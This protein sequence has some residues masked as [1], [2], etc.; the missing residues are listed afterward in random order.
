MTVEITGRRIEPPEVSDDGS[1][2]GGPGVQKKFIIS[3]LLLIVASVL[4]LGADVDPNEE[5]RLMLAWHKPAVHPLPLLKGMDVKTLSL[6]LDAGN[7]MWYEPRPEPDRW[8]AVVGVKI[9]ASPEVVW[10]VVTDY[11]LQCKIMPESF[12]ECKTRYRRGAEVKNDYKM[13]TSVFMYSFSL[14]VVDLVIEEPP[15]RLRIKTVDGDV[16]G[17]E[18][19]I[20]LVPA[21]DRRA[22]L[23]FMRCYPQLA[24]IGVTMRLA[25][26]AL[27]MAEPATGVGACNY[28]ARAYR[29]EAERRVGY[30]P[31]PQP[32][33]LT[34]S[35]LDLATLRLI[36]EGN[37]GLIR[38]TPPGKII[39]ALTYSFIN[40]PPGRVWKVITD[41]DHYQNIFSAP[42]QVESRLANQVTV[43]QETASFS[44]MG[45]RFGVYYSI[46]DAHASGIP[47][48]RKMRDQGFDDYVPFMKGQLQEIFEKY[49]PISSLF[50]D[51]D[52]T[53]QWDKERGKDLEAFIRSLQPSVIINDRLGPR[54]CMLGDYSTPEQFIPDVPPERDW[55]TCMT[56]DGASWGY[57]RFDRFWKSKTTLIRNLV[58]I[59]SKGGNFLLNVGPD[60]K[61]R[62]PAPCMKRLKEVGQWMEVNGESIYGS[63]AGPIQGATWGKTTQKPGKVFL[64]VFEWPGRELTIDNF[65]ERVSR[66]YALADQD[67]TPLAFKKNPDRISIE[68]PAS[69]PDPISSTIVLECPLL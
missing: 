22:T 47:S 23:L 52:W 8:E 31:S 4:L 48:F 40:A 67:R 12:A 62:I 69:R 15:N 29:N 6:L 19:E 21:D 7:L 5:F 34:F 36:D 61:G 10:K 44:V 68:L 45:L 58:D 55:E 25:L 27:P 20:L 14:K 60:A 32:G 57:H 59:A 1:L 35:G 51:G 24:S 42:C 13:V 2:A 9:H 39:D 53:P 18:I 46:L 54:E 43:R 50:L 56:M 38:E 65:G 28:Q 66:A 17:R 16:I 37:G 30:K 26:E 3:S 33:P 64:H 49:G 11:E 41:F 63:K